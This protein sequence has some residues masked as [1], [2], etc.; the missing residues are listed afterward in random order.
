MK[1]KKYLMACAIAPLA[2]TNTQAADLNLTGGGDIAEGYSYGNITLTGGDYQTLGNVA[3]TSLSLSSGSTLSAAGGYL[4]AQIGKDAVSTFGGASIVSTARYDSAGAATGAGHVGIGALI[5]A[6]DGYASIAGAGYVQAG[7]AKGGSMNNVSLTHGSVIGLFSNA[8]YSV[9]TNNVKM[10]LTTYAQT[11]SQGGLTKSNA[12]YTLDMSSLIRTFYTQEGGWENGSGSNLTKWSGDLTIALSNDMYN[13]II[14]NA[15]TLTLLVGSSSDYLSDGLIGE[16]L[17]IK[18][19]NADGSMQTGSYTTGGDG[20]GHSFTW[21]RE[22][23]AIPEPSTATLSLLALAGL[24]ARR[25][26]V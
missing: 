11:G 5:T 4:S 10:D 3:Y 2:L 1:L 15:E 7:G 6:Y 14:A 25:R 20:T 16:N 13:D 18:F 8:D 22:S 17:T 19:T 24:A 9:A 26:R 21:T 12:D 23:G